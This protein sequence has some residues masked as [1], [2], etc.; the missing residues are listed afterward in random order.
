VILINIIG[1]NINIVSKDQNKNNWQFDSTKY[2]NKPYKNV[3]LLVLVDSILDQVKDTDKQSSKKNTVIRKANKDIVHLKKIKEHLEKLD[4]DIDEL[5]NETRKEIKS[6]Q[7]EKHNLIKSAFKDIDRLIKIEHHLI[8]LEENDTTDT[9]KAKLS[10]RKRKEQTVEVIK[11][12]IEHLLKIERKL[13]EL[14]KKDPK[15]HREAEKIYYETEFLKGPEIHDRETFSIDDAQYHDHLHK[16][17]SK[18]NPDIHEKI[19][20]YLWGNT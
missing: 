7:T 11:E 19:R 15:E 1:L 17:I 14:T 20:N 9:E 16:G 5:K 6:Y 2:L 3:E 10:H 13:I 12:K 18:Y 8:K 4:I